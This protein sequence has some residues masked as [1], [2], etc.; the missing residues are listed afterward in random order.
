MPTLVY[1]GLRRSMFNVYSVR[2][3]GSFF[4]KACL[5]FVGKDIMG[6]N[7]SQYDQLQNHE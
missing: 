5:I 1:I 4:A 2:R 6:T 3:N 7:V